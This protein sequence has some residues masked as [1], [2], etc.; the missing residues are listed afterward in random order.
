MLIHMHTAFLRQ[1]VLVARSFL[2]VC[3]VGQDDVNVL[4]RQSMHGKGHVYN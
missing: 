2:P 4:L 3:T 1:L